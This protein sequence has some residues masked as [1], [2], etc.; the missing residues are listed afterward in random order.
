M[1]NVDLGLADAREFTHLDVGHDADDLATDPCEVEAAPER[2]LPRKELRRKR[3]TDDR[4][5][6]T[7]EV[8]RIPN[9]TALQDG[10]TER[11]EEAGC[12][13]AEK[14]DVV[15]APAF[16]AAAD[17]HREHAP[18]HVAERQEA[19]IRR[20]RHARQRANLRQHAV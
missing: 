3:R 14:R 11:L 13:V 16:D 17:P 12:H 18:A 15:L 9:V 5:R 19:G 1:R 4:D 7:V 20:A 8:I 2:L 6:R 10:Y